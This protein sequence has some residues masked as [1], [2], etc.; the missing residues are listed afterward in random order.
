MNIPMTPTN[1]A[2]GAIGLILIALL[3]WRLLRRKPSPDEMERRRRIAV[4]ASGKLG[5]G[6][7]I[8]VEGAAV[9]YSYAV[10]GV[11][12]TASQDVAPFITQLPEN[13]LELVGPTRIKFDPRNPANSIVICEDWNGLCWVRKS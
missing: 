6:E 11:G 9:V 4:N 7:V 3:A 8:D 2:A 13:T 5:D 10:A 1:L 12:H